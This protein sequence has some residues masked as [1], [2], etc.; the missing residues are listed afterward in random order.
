[1]LNNSSVT[2]YLNL[3]NTEVEHIS[4]LVDESNYHYHSQLLKLKED[5]NLFQEF[6]ELFQNRFS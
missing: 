3:W 4:E 1:M 5:N 6:I 2:D